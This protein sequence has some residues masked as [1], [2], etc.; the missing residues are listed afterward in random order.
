M[1][2]L[3]PSVLM[4]AWVASG[5]HRAAL[6]SALLHFRLLSPATWNPEMNT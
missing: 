2:A 5:S 1:R 3:S 4:T 6:S